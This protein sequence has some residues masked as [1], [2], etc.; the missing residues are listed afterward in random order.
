MIVIAYSEGLL[1]DE[2]FMFLYETNQP[3]NLE[4]PYY[5][6]EEF[7][8]DENISEAEC[9]AEFRFERGDIERLADVLQLPPT[10]TCPQ[11][12]V[13]E[14]IEGLC[15]LLRRV[16]YPCRYSD[17]VSRFA[18]PVPVLCM[19]SN[20]VLNYIFD[21]HHH[22]ITTWNNSILSPFAIQ[23]YFD[24][25]SDKVLPLT[26]VLGLWMELFARFAGRGNTNGLFITGTRGYMPLNFRLLLFL[27]GL[28]DICSVL[29]VSL[30]IPTVSFVFGFKSPVL[31]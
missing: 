29:W 1:T 21:L 10:F 20:I 24:A 16:A 26:T 9:K 12:S 28:L 6:Y 14:R 17:M 18:K 19:V 7:N 3:V 23:Q 30:V 31:A 13:C 22:R 11:G 4:L 2:E 8:F 25:V 5:E 27:M 15:I